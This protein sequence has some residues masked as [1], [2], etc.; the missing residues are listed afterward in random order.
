MYPVVIVGYGV[1]GRIFGNVFAQLGISPVCVDSQASQNGASS[2]AAYRT[3]GE[4]PEA[5][6]KQPAYWF[7]CTPT[8]SHLGVVREIID[9]TTDPRIMVEKP[10]CC[11]RDL[12]DFRAAA[13]CCGK[14]PW[15]NNH[16]ED[17]PNLIFAKN[18]LA[19]QQAPI[20]EL[21]IEISKNRREDEK[22]G[23]HVDKRMGIW[24]HDGFHMLTIARRLLSKSDE[25][26]LFSRKGDHIFCKGSDDHISCVEETTILPSGTKLQLRAAMDGWVTTKY[27]DPVLLSG[28][29]RKRRAQGILF[30]GTAFM[31]TFCE[32]ESHEFVKEEGTYLFTAKTA[33]GKT[34]HKVWRGKNALSTHVRRFFANGDNKTLIEGMQQTEH[35]AWM[36]ENTYGSTNECVT[37]RDI[38]VQPLFAI[39][40]VS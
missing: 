25:S 40:A 20:K 26:D 35:L 27:G 14:R 6:R 11:S 32:S 39:P 23:R 13:I 31:L 19:R 36:A 10:V 12:S 15:V 22:N 33:S 29:E 16:Y 3:I 17:A 1:M 8:E 37:R 18:W 30:D 21:Y 24:G 4:V 28:Y 34:E 38:V 2:C 9:A 7:V 5:I